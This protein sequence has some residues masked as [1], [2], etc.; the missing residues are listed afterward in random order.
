MKGTRARFLGA[1]SLALTAAAAQATAGEGSQSPSDLTA[2][3]LEQLMDTEVTLASKKLQPWFESPAAIYVITREEIERS[4]ATTIAEVLR[5]VPSLSVARADSNKWAISS[6][7]LNDVFANKLLVLIDGRSVYTP[8]FAG[9]FWDV[10]DVLLEDIERIEV[11]RGPGATLW[12]ANAVNGVI[13]VV[14]RDARNTQGG[15]LSVGAGSEERGLAGARYGGKF[16]SDAYYRV[17]AK[18]VK[19]DAFANAA[20]TPAADGWQAARGGFRVDWRVAPR[21]QLT[22]QGDLYSGRFGQTAT[23]S[24]L[25]PPFMLTRSSD[26]PASGANLLA[27]WERTQ[28]QRSAIDLQVYYDQTDRDLKLDVLRE[29]RH[30]LDAELQHRFAMGERH[31]IVW[32]LGYRRTDDVIDGGFPASFVPDRRASYVESA[33]VQDE[34]R[35]AGDRVRVVVGSKFEHND[36]SGFEVQP[37]VRALWKPSP[38]HALWAAVSRAVRTPSR[39]EHDARF[40]AA[41]IPSTVGPLVVTR[42]VGDPRMGSEEL[43]AYEA[44]YRLKAGSSL[45]LEVAAFHNSYRGLGTLEPRTPFLEPTPSPAHL[46]LPMALDNGAD[47]N[48]RGAELAAQWSVSSRWKLAAAYA[49]LDLRLRPGPGSQDVTARAREGDSP[50][51]QFQARSFLTLPWKLDFDVLLYGASGLGNQAVPGYLR[52]DASLTFH[53]NRG[54]DARLALQNALEPRHPEF[55]RTWIGQ[56]ATQV[57]RGVHLKLTWKF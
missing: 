26:V 45:F 44:G 13:N 31:E 36:Y 41:V 29:R 4:G 34:V 22:V 46:V 37:N 20:G 6:R 25:T 8:L 57:E 39:A 3:S 52:A 33:F 54:L 19:H 7:G 51:H 28:S 2:L 11:I 1:V 23:F 17:Y 35:L 10:Q 12:G 24:S 47:A 38:R 40:N 56:H 14:T 53:V 50:R 32:G 43:V 27:R 18:Y 42:I 48:S 15:L 9:V 55:G 21:D 30:T 16:A 49:W 5:L